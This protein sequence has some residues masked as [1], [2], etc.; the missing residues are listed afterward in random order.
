MIENLKPP[1][2]YT[3]AKTTF[4]FHLSLVV[5]RLKPP[6]A[7]R[8]PSMD[9]LSRLSAL[10]PQRSHEGRRRCNSWDETA[11]PWGCDTLALNDLQ[12]EK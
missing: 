12:W 5:Q 11:A 9:L 7:M 1:L 10:H 3:L 8:F 6:H 4:F 2:Y